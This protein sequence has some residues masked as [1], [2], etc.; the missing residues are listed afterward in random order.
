MAFNTK[1][2][3]WSDVRVVLLGRE[4]TGIQAVS[5]KMAQ[6]KEPVYGRG[7]EPLAIQSGNKS[8]EGSI[9]LLQSEL[10]ALLAAVKAVNSLYHLTDISFD[11]VVSYGNGASSSTDIIQSVE[12]TEFDKG[13]GQTDKSMKIELPFLATGIKYGV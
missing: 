9:T 3:T 2:Y 5:Y 10:E 11:L 6:D 8:F 12:I 7:N 13:M 1:E 4:L